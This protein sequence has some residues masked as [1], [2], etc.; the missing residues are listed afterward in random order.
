[1]VLLNILKD[2]YKDTDIAEQT[3]EHR[4]LLCIP[5]VCIIVMCQKITFSPTPSAVHWVDRLISVSYTQQK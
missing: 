2:L 4:I 5:L 3:I 1:M